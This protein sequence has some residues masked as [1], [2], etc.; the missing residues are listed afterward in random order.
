[1]NGNLKHNDGTTNLHKK[2]H[3]GGKV[4]DYY[5]ASG[6]WTQ[7]PCVLSNIYLLS[8]W[9]YKT[10]AIQQLI[11]EN[12]VLRFKKALLR[13]LFRKKEM[14]SNIREKNSGCAGRSLG[15]KSPI[16]NKMKTLFF[17]VAHFPP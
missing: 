16:D 5:V 8:E 11:T 9:K 3:L 14:Y 10:I 6:R 17:L 2:M 4:N 13:N 12:H 7:H 15:G 1:M